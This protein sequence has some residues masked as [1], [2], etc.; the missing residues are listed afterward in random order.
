MQIRSLSVS[1]KPNYLNTIGGYFL[2][3]CCHVNVSPNNSSPFCILLSFDIFKFRLFLIRS[4]KM[5]ILVGKGV[6]HRRLCL[7]SCYYNF[8]TS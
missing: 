7:T 6:V 1:G 5:F 8:R 4:L 2:V 3:S